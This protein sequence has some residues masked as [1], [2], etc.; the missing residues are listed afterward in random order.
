VV[1]VTVAHTFWLFGFTH[2]AGYVPL[3]FG[4]VHVTFVTLLRTFTTF[5]CL[6]H[7]LRLVYVTALLVGLRFGYV[8]GCGYVLVYVYVWFVAVGCVYCGSRLFSRI[9]RFGYGFGLGCYGCLLFGCCIRW[10]VGFVTTFTLVVRLVVCCTRTL[11]IFG[12]VWLLGCGWLVRLVVVTWLFRGCGWFVGS[13]GWI[14]WFW[15]HLRWFGWLVCFTVVVVT[16]LF[17]SV[18]YVGYCVARLVTY[19]WLVTGLH[20]YVGLYVGL[21]A[22]VGWLRWLFPFWVV[23]VVCYVYVLLGYTVV[24]VE[25]DVAVCLVRLPKF[26]LVAGWLFGCAVGLRCRVGGYIAHT[27]WFGWLDTLHRLFMR[28]RLRRVCRYVLVGRRYVYGWFTRT[29]VRCVYVYTRRCVCRFT[30]T[31]LPH[32]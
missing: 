19:V 25:L 15:L 9:Y 26:V 2:V 8:Y 14:C 23:A 1:V 30:F 10:L 18:G 31:R 27:R 24:R 16:H 29:F 12:Y 4:C 3:R 13:V 22:V 5:G 17:G 32:V 6:V 28:L 20:T 21:V 7:I 11:D